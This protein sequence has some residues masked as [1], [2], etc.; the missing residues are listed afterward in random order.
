MD[1]IAFMNMIDAMALITAIVM[2]IMAYVDEVAAMMIMVV[3][4]VM[5]LAAR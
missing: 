3:T 4:T 5:A 2:T 1:L